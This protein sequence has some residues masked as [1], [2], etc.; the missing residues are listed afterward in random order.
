MAQGTEA[1]TLD[2]DPEAPGD[3]DDG[4]GLGPDERDR[5]LLDGSW[6][7]KYYSGRVRSIDWTTIG[8]ALGLL[9]VIGLV[10]PGLLVFLR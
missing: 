1:E 3:D 7:E 2:D 5:D 10:L 6:E 8:V 9:A 4:P